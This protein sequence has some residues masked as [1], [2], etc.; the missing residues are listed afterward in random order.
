MR[1]YENKS[2]RLPVY[3][4]NQSATEKDKPSPIGNFY[5]LNQ[6]NAGSGTEKWNGK[7]VVVNFFFTHCSGVCPKMTGN[8][9]KVQEAYKNDTGIIINSLTVDPESDSASQLKIYARRYGIQ[10][11]KWQLLTGDKKEIYRLA[12]NEFKVLATDGDG[13]AGD[14]IHSEKI[15]LV[16]TQKRIRGYYDG[17][18]INEM[19]QLIKDILKLKNEN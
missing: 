3:G 8:L 2:G 4:L 14:F 7:I 13:G 15:V 12:R 16:D 19:K 6:D 5:L 9:I 1:W 11:T 10:S 17:T 18:D